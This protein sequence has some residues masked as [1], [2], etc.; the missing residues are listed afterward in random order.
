MTKATTV[1][2]LIS[3]DDKNDPRVEEFDMF[4]ALKIRMR[5]IPA[6]DPQY[7]LLANGRLVSWDWSEPELNING[8]EVGSAPMPAKKERAKRRTREQMAADALAKSE[9]KKAKANGTTAVAS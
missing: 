9:A 1:Y 8:I 2:T 4:S 7:K 3:T 6:N 5:G